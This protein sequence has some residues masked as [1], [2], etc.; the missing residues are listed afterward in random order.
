M[1]NE[2]I[3]LVEDD[4]K[5]RQVTGEYL[6]NEGYTIFEAGDGPHALQQWEEHRP[7]LIVLDWMLPSMSG[8]DVARAIRARGSGTPI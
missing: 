3:L 6:R 4:L 7:D 1:A 2:R 8:L 5:L